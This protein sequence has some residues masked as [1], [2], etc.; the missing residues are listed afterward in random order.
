MTKTPNES[1]YRI[2]TKTRNDYITFN[3]KKTKMTV[4]L[5]KICELGETN[6]QTKELSSFMKFLLN[7]GRDNHS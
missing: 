4:V 6:K 5:C 1:Q 2:Y 7:A 3:F